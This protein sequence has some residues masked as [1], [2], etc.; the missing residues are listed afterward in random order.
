[1]LWAPKQQLWKSSYQRDPFGE[2]PTKPLATKSCWSLPRLS[3]DKTSS[4]LRIDTLAFPY[5]PI[6]LQ[7]S[8]P[9]KSPNGMINL[10]ETPIAKGVTSIKNLLALFCQGRSWSIH[11]VAPWCCWGRLQWHHPASAAANTCSSPVSPATCLTE[12]RCPDQAF[13]L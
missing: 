1:M 13:S 9:S 10:F 5:G 3:S 11:A 7:D 6:V 12:G 8:V 2:S 4:Y